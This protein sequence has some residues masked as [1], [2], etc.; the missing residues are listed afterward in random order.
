MSGLMF[1]E[2]AAETVLFEP[3]PPRPTSNREGLPSLAASCAAGPLEPVLAVPPLELL[4]DELLL[5][6]EPPLDELPEELLDELLFDALP[7]GWAVAA[8][9]AVLEVLSLPPHAARTIPSSAGVASRRFICNTCV[10]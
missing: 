1:C 5:L 9:T 8:V 4:L 7:T 2:A 6:E 3:C 10:D